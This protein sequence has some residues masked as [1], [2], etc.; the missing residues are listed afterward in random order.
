MGLMKFNPSDWKVFK[1]CLQK[2]FQGKYHRLYLTDIFQ[3]LIENNIPVYGV[4]F[5]GKWA[6]VDSLKDYKIMKKIFNK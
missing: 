4:K 6:E 3:K 1:K 5:N 2:E